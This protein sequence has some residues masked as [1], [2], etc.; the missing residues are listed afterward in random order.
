MRK[1][2]KKR[3]L[4]LAAL[5]LYLGISRGDIQ[6]ADFDDALSVLRKY[7]DIDSILLSTV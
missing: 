2:T 5:A 4:E 6:M 3:A 7:Y 1:M